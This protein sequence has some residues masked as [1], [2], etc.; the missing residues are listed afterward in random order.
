MILE[1]SKKIRGSYEILRGTF[2]SYSWEFWVK[3]CIFSDVF[4]RLLHRICESYYA[5]VSR[6]SGVTDKLYLRKFH[7]KP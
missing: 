6:I 1:L 4:V 3:K 7:I 5:K 2:A